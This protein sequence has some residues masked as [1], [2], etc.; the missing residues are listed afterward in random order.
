MADRFREAGI[1]AVAVSGETDAADRR[2]ALD[3]LRAGSTQVVFS[4]DLFNEGVDVRDADTLLLLRPTDSPVLFIQQLGRGL[5]KAEGK[6]C[7]VLDFVGNHRK[8]FRFDRRF[9][10]LLGGS[11]TDLQRQ[12]ELGFPFLPAGC[13]LELEPIAQEIVLRSLREAVP[14]DWRSRQQE[15]AA[16][17]DV[18]LST[19]LSETGLDLDDIYTSKRS[20]SDL[21][22]AVGLATAPAG[23]AED[24]LLRAVG[25]LLHIDDA[26]RDRRVCRVRGARRAARSGHPN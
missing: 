3:G 26:Q 14:S 13:H 22:R 21:R 23:P 6:I 1:D 24:A 2:A 17:G 15:L 10:A 16:L 11:R 8:E 18:S 5:R 9:R 4:V 7:T 20:W 12:I 25:R 19:Y